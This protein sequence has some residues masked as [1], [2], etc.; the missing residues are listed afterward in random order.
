MHTTPL[1]HDATL[2]F[3]VVTVYE[4]VVFPN[5]VWF[6]YRCQLCRLN[7]VHVLYTQLVVSDNDV[8][9][10]LQS[11]PWVAGHPCICKVGLG[12]SQLMTIQS[13]AASNMKPKFPLKTLL[14]F[15]EVSAFLANERVH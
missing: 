15:S 5:V 3:Q 9:A 14:P 8:L 6:H 1:L 12:H 11:M 7:R 13:T 2:R 4:S 10:I